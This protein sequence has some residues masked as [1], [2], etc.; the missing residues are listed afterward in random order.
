[1]NKLIHQ[2]S[3]GEAGSSRQCDDY[4]LRHFFFVLLLFI[5][6]L[7]YVEPF[8]I[9]HLSPGLDPSWVAAL[10]YA[11]D[12]RISFG[13]DVIY[14]GGPL[15]PLYHKGFVPSYAIVIIF[16]SLALTLHLA[17][18]LSRVFS[19]ASIGLA[20]LFCAALAVA[21]PNR[22]VVLMLP[23]YLLV[24]CAAR[25][26]LSILLVAISAIAIT[27]TV[28]AKFSVLPLAL[29]SLVLTDGL[30]WYRE[31]YIPVAIPTAIAVTPMLF[32]IVDQ[33][34]SN[35]IA[36]LASSLDMASGF[37][38]AMGGTGS[39]AE[40]ASWIGAAGLLI[41][42]MARRLLLC[43][44]AAF[45][46]ECLATLVFLWLTFKSGFVR[47]D[48]HS[49]A[50]WS[51]L[52]WIALLQLA[53]TDNDVDGLN[54][55]LMFACLAVVGIFGF[56][57]M[58]FGSS[59][60]NFSTT[61]ATVR[62]ASGQANMLVTFVLAPSAWK[63]A[64]ATSEMN[65]R[66]RT[67]SSEPLPKLKGT[68]DAIPSMQSAIIANG[69]AYFPRPSVQEYTAYTTF[70]IEKNRAFFS[71]AGAPD[72]L[73]FAP[74]SIDSRHPASAEGASWPI[75][76][77]RY[78]PIQAAGVNVILKRRQVPVDLR[79]GNARIVQAAGGEH[80]SVEP[81]KGA[82][83]ARV[84]LKLSILGRLASFVFKPGTAYIQMH[85]TDGSIREYRIIPDQ[86]ALGFVISPEVR[87]AL[88]YVALHAG[89]GAMANL[90]QVREIAVQ[91]PWWLRWQY[92][93]PIRYEFQVMDLSHV[94]AASVVSPL[95]GDLQKIARDTLAIT[96]SNRLQ[97]PLSELSALD[98]VFAHAPSE[99][100]VRTGVALRLEV[101]FGLRQGSYENG[102]GTGGVCFKVRSRQGVS[103]FE[104]CLRP[105]QEAT[106][107]GVQRAELSV[108]ENEEIKLITEC[109][110]DC[111][112]DWSYW[113]AARLKD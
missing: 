26:H 60:G 1:M 12:N 54:P 112:W 4:R 13:V 6:M 11:I 75:F 84:G 47:H 90:P 36:F 63:A 28:L 46:V 8:T 111:A 19:R 80:V 99:L 41:A 72:Y 51:A 30:R 56:K 77:S 10:S 76:L 79:L 108:P 24:L 74:G 86:A 97:P 29:A 83:F 7:A 42:L 73:I 92:Q 66:E 31:R 89:P 52:T 18:S 70:A 35:A 20:A 103:L 39:V 53:Q 98:G 27:V 44:Q 94:Q 102:G 48:L 33:D 15:S 104:R 16:I 45:A 81:E 96:S 95:V 2:D 100:T 49:L 64:V 87:S 55:T 106:D 113:K 71:G 38:P 67:A 40:L 25:L 82:I 88:D 3:P 93:S 5:L 78:V 91:I 85:H 69:L 101:E 32:W 110:G 65:A 109:A 59:L 37:A 17:Y 107:R 14:T 9:F 22:D 57:I 68:V 58:L 34:P 62:Q 23:S 105:V 61:F 21:S 43:R 50:A